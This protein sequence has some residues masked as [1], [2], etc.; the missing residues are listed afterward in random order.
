MPA[1][2]YKDFGAT[3]EPGTCFWCGSRLPRHAVTEAERV[4]SPDGMGYTTVA[5]KTGAVRLGTQDDG[6]FC[7]LR[8]AHYFAVNMARRDRRFRPDNPATLPSD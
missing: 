3:N 5:V 7:G 8:C 4:S 2:N 6:F 1:P